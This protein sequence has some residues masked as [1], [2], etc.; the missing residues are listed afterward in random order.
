MRTDY[1][2]VV[3]IIASATVISVLS[4]DPT[5]SADFQAL[6][7]AGE[8]YHAGVLDQIYP[9]EA[10]TFTS[11]PSIE[12]VEHVAAQG[13]N[14]AVFPYIYP[15][16]WAALAAKLVPVTS[17]VTLST[18]ASYVNPV[19]IG[20]SVFLAWRLC[21]LSGIKNMRASVFVL[22][23]LVVIMGTTIGTIALFQNQIQI[24]VS[25][26][27]LLGL[28]REKSQSPIW[29]GAAMGLAAAIKL[30]PAIIAILWLVQGKRKPFAYFVIFGGG[31]G[32]LSVVIC[33]WPLHALFLHQISIISDS[34]LLNGINY[35]F[36][37]SVANIFA[38]DQMVFEL[39]TF[40]TL[41]QDNAGGN[42]T[43]AKPALWQLV[44][45][46][47]VL[48]SI[49][50]M[51]IFVRR[52]RVAAP[53]AFWPFALT[54]ISLLSPLAWS[55]HF[56]PAASFAPALIA[57]LG[58]RAGARILALVF[59]PLTMGL[60]P[61]FANITTAIDAQQLVGFLCMTTYCA[62]WAYILAKQVQ[63]ATFGE[64]GSAK[65]QAIP[66]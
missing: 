32:L 26:L 50:A 3:L 6:W 41:T 34:I 36:E 25:F 22:I 21:Y 20:A 61:T 33:G 24:L 58:V 56:L 10:D 11:S 17:F 52:Y 2:W 30:Y 15:P 19:L 31:L 64:V 5:L 40:N 16:I 9:P 38:Q 8:F 57:I 27:I 42:I 4:F 37:A 59:I 60:L 48:G 51:A 49:V 18:I 46:V 23:G 47:L 62:T 54:L 44:S 45:K 12:W 14:S 29:A 55:H 35:A 1:L 13:Q 28:E 66:A 63:P 43:M 53:V 7:I 39:F 65:N